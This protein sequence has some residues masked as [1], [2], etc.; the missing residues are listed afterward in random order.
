MTI[1]TWN[2]VAASVDYTTGTYFAYLHYGS[3]SYGTISRSKNIGTGLSYGTGHITM[4]GDK[5]YAKFK[6]TIKDFNFY[7]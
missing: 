5:W 4:G 1:N 3:E 2:F 6:G 7:Y